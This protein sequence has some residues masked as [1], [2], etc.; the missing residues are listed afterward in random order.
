MRE[1]LDL[2]DLI[3][4]AESAPAYIKGEQWAVTAVMVLR[5]V[6]AEEDALYRRA[7]ELARLP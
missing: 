4:L 6:R 5:G 7:V 3:E 1:Q 2:T